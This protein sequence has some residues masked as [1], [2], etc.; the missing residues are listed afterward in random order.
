MNNTAVDLLAQRDCRTHHTTPLKFSR[1][2][3][4]NGERHLI[5]R[6]FHTTVSLM[7][8]QLHRIFSRVTV[9]CLLCL[10]LDAGNLSVNA[11]MTV[12]NQCA[13]QAQQDSDLNHKVMV[14]FS[15]I[16]KRNTLRRGN[17]ATTLT[18]MCATHVPLSRAES[19]T[20]NQSCQT[21]HSLPSRP[22]HQQISIYRL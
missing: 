6:L 7:A 2:H 14:K 8:L 4:V 12:E 11:Q 19:V 3:G 5:H 15:Q 9:T 21:A 16:E 20:V 13:L 18:G 17:S 10:R 1:K 22:L